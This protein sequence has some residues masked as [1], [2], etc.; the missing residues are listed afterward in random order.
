[1]YQFFFSIVSSTGVVAVSASNISV[2]VCCGTRRV[3]LRGLLK[4]ISNCSITFCLVF[5]L[6]LHIDWLGQESPVF[7]ALTHRYLMIGIMI[8]STSRQTA[9]I[10]P[11]WNCL[12][13]QDGHM[14]Q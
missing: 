10:L 9:S 1:M 11:P 2:G 7:L 8:N 13:H 12:S 4:L 3:F 14:T 5:R 6:L